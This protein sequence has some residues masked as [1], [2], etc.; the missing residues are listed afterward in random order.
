[1]SS[2]PIRRADRAMSHERMLET[3]AGGYS[4][5]LATVSEDG[6]PINVPDQML[7]RPSRWRPLS[8]F[9][10]WCIGR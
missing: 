4:G 10:C 5:H 8:F 2:P 3:L 9:G 6:F 1:M 7:E